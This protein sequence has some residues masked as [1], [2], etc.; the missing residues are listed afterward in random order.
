MLVAYARATGI[1][2][3]DLRHLFDICNPLVVDR[4]ARASGNA[5]N[6][7]LPPPVLPPTPAAALG[8]PD[9]IVVRLRLLHV[10]GDL[11]GHADDSDLLGF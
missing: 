5:L 8:D 7:N 9:A 2:S 11:D 4:L 10:A 3:N 1:S 6:L